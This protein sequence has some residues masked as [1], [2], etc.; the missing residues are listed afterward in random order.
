MLIKDWKDLVNSVSHSPLSLVIYRSDDYIHYYALRCIF[1]HPVLH[2]F[3]IHLQCSLR[4][5][6]LHIIG[7]L[8]IENTHLQV[9]FFSK[10]GD[11]QC[12]LSS[13][14]KDSPYYKAFE[15]KASIWEQRLGDLDE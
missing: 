11:H 15:D 3:Y 13:S 7:L 6:T 2:N 4:S 5:L 10:F 14:L 1:T 8:I 12:L 9:F